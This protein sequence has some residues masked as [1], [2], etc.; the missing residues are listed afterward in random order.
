MR[1]LRLIKPPVN[2]LFSKNPAPGAPKNT[3]EQEILKQVEEVKDIMHNNIDKMVKNI[4]NLEVL[5]DKTGNYSI[6]VFVKVIEF[7][8]M[9]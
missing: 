3:K 1:Y 6:S 7:K 2:F 9:R 8:Q 5:N 4:D